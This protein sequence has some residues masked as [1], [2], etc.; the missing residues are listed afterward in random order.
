MQSDDRGWS[1]V[2][3]AL[4]QPADYFE[5]RF[6][7]EAQRAYRV[8]VRLRADGDSKYNDSVWL[9][10]SNATDATGAAKWRI[11]T[12]AA[13]LVNLEACGTCGSAGWGW[14]NRAW[15]LE[16]DPVVWFPS[17]E[18]QSIRVQTREDGVDIDQIV[19]SPVAFFDIAPGQPFNDAT[20]VPKR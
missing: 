20:I 9:Q 18:I 19:L 12:A 6:A 4:A 8:W 15:W 13:L 5:L 16:E 10:F 1:A 14:Q 3:H 11:G 17:G 7:A 2:D